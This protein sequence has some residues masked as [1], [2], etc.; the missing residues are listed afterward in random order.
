[1][2]S[3]TTDNTDVHPVYDAPGCG[4]AGY[5]CLLLGFFLIGIIGIVSSSL[6]ILQ[7]SFETKPFATIPGNQVKVWRLQ[8]MRDAKLL[9][10][11]EVPLH[12]HDESQDGTK[13][14]AMS[15]DALLRLDNGKGWRIPYTDIKE[16][17]AVYESKRHVAVIETASGETLPCF[18]RPTEGM[19]RFKYYLAEKIPSD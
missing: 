6:S 17:R 14:C 18:F 5:S 16:I 3:D 2:S 12:Y 19:E 11:T 1:M 13:A 7:T 9:S 10:L 15:E 8:P 4:V